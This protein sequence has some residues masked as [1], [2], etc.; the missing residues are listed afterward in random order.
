VVKLNRNGDGIRGRDNKS[1]VIGI[2]KN[3]IARSDALK[4]GRVK[5]EHGGAKGWALDHTSVDVKGG[6]CQR[7]ETGDMRAVREKVPEPLINMIREGEVSKFMEEGGMPSHIKSL[8]EIKSN[9]V[10][11][12]LRDKKGGNIVNKG[13]YSCSGRTRRTEGILVR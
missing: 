4:V 2:L 5:D 12:W 1:T 11:I 3:R 7:L 10:D 13:N 9:N 8:R 6:W